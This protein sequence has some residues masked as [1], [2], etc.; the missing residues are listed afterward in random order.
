MMAGNNG[1][2]EVAF[3]TSITN[4]NILHLTFSY[5]FQQQLSYIKHLIF[6]QLSQ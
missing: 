6:I 3:I 2:K 1:F 4:P 5:S